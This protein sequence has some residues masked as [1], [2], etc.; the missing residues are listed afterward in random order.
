MKKR[1][2][3]EKERHDKKAR[4]EHLKA[5]MK[6]LLR[7]KKKKKGNPKY[8]PEPYTIIELEG[9]QAVLRRGDTTLRRETQKFKRLHTKDDDDK[10][11]GR[12]PDDWEDRTI[13]SDKTKVQ[14]RQH[15]PEMTQSTVT[16]GSSNSDTATPDDETR[17]TDVFDDDTATCPEAQTRRSTRRTKPPSRY[18]SWIEK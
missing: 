14:T 3:E 6:V 17:P 7:N 13:R 9:R 5:G 16:P 8:D 11:T 18:G 2:N 1:A 10:H 12:Q 4:E 15:V